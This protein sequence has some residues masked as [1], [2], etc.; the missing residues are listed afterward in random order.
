MEPNTTYLILVAK[1]FDVGTFGTEVISFTFDLAGTVTPPPANDNC[2]T[3]RKITSFPFNSTDLPLAANHEPDTACS[4]VNV[5]QATNGVWYR[6]DGGP[7]GFT[8]SVTETVS[9]PN[10]MYALYQGA[11]DG[12]E[13][14]CQTTDTNRTFTLAS[15]TTYYLL[16][17]RESNNDFTLGATQPNLT[18]TA[19]AGTSGACCTGTV[20][21]ATTIENCTAGF[22]PGA[23]CDPLNPVAC[24]PANINGVG[25]VS[26]QDIFDFLGF[27]F[28][29][30]PRAD[31]NGNGA[32]TV[33]DIFDFLAAYFTAC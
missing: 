30:D 9:S 27:Y 11:C 1:G 5:A 12:F 26:V 33:Q 19:A 31:F 18:I 16:V 6:I 20:C 17:A 7:A 10:V 25:G 3:A 28:S 15:G 14:D 23:I 13:L 24:C 32:I 2:A 8:L 29:G 4:G 22:K 21:V